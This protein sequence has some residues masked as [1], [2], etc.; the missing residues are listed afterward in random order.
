MSPE[1]RAELFEEIQILIDELDY[2][3]EQLKND[4][5]YMP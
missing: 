1:D 2:K 5:G 4:N 3:I